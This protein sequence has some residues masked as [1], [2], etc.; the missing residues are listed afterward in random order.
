VAVVG[1]EVVDAAETDDEDEAAVADAEEA[2]ASTCMATDTGEVDAADGAAAAGL[3]TL[4]AGEGRGVLDAKATAVTGTEA[5]AGARA[6]ATA[7]TGTDAGAERET[8]ADAGVVGVTASADNCRTDRIIQQQCARYNIRTRAHPYQH[9]HPTQK[10]KT[11]AQ[12]KRGPG[13]VPL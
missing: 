10:P 5:G 6:E 2:R 1:K 8:G 3:V 13:V 9:P 7:V 11:M 12:A 4:G